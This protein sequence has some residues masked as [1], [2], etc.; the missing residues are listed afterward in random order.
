QSARSTSAGGQEI[1]TDGGKRVKG[2]KRHIAVCSLG[3][4]LSVVV[5]A[6]NL[7]DGSTA[8]RLVAGLDPAKY[9]R[10]Q[11]VQGDN[12]YHNHAFRAFL[13]ADHRPYRLVISSKA[14]KDTGFIPL[15]QRWV[16]ERTFGWLGNYRLLS[17]EYEKTVWS[18]EADI[19]LAMIHLM[20]R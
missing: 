8:P 15:G 2:R 19:Q 16:V 6:A 12:K 17:R 13:F 4:V 7:D 1:G 9:P 11:E 18:S 3:F 10:L 5:T 20:L 14:E